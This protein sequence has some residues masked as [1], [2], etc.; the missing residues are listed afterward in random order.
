MQQTSNPT[1]RATEAD[2]TTPRK[3][4]A[5]RQLSTRIDRAL[6]KKLRHIAAEH[7][8][9]LQAIFNAALPEWLQRNE[10]AEK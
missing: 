3:A 8:L 1:A 4:S 10:E 6:Y 7:D 2:L 9:T 5:M